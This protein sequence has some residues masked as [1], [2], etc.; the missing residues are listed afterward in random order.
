M[1]AEYCSLIERRRRRSTRALLRA[2]HRLLPRLYAEA[3]CLKPDRDS[4]PA[5]GRRMSHDGWWKLYKSLQAQLGF[6]GFYREVFDPFARQEEP[7]LADLADDLADIYRDL[8]G[9]LTLW[10]NGHRGAAVERWAEDFRIHWS[11]HASGAIRALGWLEF[12]Y[13]MA[14]SAEDLD[15][16]LEG[17]MPPLEE[18]S[19]K[20][21]LRPPADSLRCIG[22]KDRDNGQG[23]KTKPA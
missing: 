7:I 16:F 18:N 6:F 9:G 5:E 23:Q 19:A 10:A 4:E 12:H 21:E 3:L 22:L 2:V 20:G 14:R 11:E 1:A 13:R 15:E 17:Q 8:K